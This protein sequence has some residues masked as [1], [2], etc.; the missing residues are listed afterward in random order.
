MAGTSEGA[1]KGWETRRALLMTAPPSVKRAAYRHRQ[2]KGV[3][4]YMNERFMYGGEI[5]T[6]GEIIKDLHRVSGG[7][8]VLIDRYLQGMERTQG[9]H[10]MGV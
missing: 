8:Q 10:G 1:R 4:L 2:L 6:R 3:D 5:K 7:R 9:Q